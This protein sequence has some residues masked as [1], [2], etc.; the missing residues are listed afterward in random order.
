MSA[1]RRG[2]RA[3]R[4]K[5]SHTA[6]HV[7]TSIVAQTVGD[8]WRET[9]EVHFVRRLA[10]KPRV[11]PR[12]VVPFGCGQELAKKGFTSI[13][14][15]R[16]ASEQALDRQDDSLHHGNRAVLA[17]RSIARPLDALSFAPFSEAVAVEL[18]ATIADNVL[19]D[20]WDRLRPEALT[21]APL[22]KG[23]GSSWLWQ[24]CGP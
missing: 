7:A 5:A 1:S 19:G 14:H 11:R 4:P 20:A 22:P 23:E 10:T 16:Q 12:L 3:P 2:C 17:D 13:R 8:D 6:N 9:S 15:K 24:S 18:L 21:P